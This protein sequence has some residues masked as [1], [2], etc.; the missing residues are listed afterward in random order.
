MLLTM[1]LVVD[2]NAIFIRSMGMLLR[3]V[4][5]VEINA[6]FIQQMIS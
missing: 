4:W 1:S 6:I 3:M 2:E 5:A